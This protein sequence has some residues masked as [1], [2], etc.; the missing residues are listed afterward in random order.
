[1]S[2][3]FAPPL[4]KYAISLLSNKIISAIPVTEYNFLLKSIEETVTAY[5]TY[6][7]SAKGIM[8]DI[9]TDYKD[10]DFKVDELSKKLT[11]RENV[12]FLND[13]LTKMG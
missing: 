3:I 11:N 9:A 5:Y 2:S 1:L 6:V 4:T 13:V 7:N 10:L 8:A 12:E